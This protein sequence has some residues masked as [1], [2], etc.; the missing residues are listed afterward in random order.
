MEQSKNWVR[1]YTAGLTRPLTAGSTPHSQTRHIAL[2]S[3]IHISI[4]FTTVLLSRGKENSVT[5]AK[6]TEAK[7]NKVCPS[8]T[9]F[10]RS[11]HTF[12]FNSLQSALT[13]NVFG[14]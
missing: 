11:G 1:R 4:S 9:T 6:V 5:V 14:G 3:S 8:W 2:S 10:T 12:Y 7:V 13:L